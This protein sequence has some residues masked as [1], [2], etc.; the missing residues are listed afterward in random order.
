MDAAILAL[1]ILAYIGVA[2]L[3]WKRAGRRRRRAPL[4][5]SRLSYVP[6]DSADRRKRCKANWFTGRY[7]G[8]LTAAE[9]QRGRHVQTLRGDLVRSPA[10]ARIAD[11]LYAR[12][13]HYEYE[14]DVRGFRP[15]FYLPDHGIVVEYWGMQPKGHPMRR[16]KTGAYLGAGYRLVSLEPGKEVGL[17][18]DLRRQ[19]YYKMQR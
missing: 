2:V 17:E 4:P 10:E 14:A 12:G 1:A 3:A 8:G 18:A 13:L 11:Y 6:S 16:R 9:W 15:D 7:R 19:L 5:P